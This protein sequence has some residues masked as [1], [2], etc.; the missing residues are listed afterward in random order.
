MRNLKTIR[1]C[2]PSDGSSKSSRRSPLPQPA[3]IAGSRRLATTLSMHRRSIVAVPRLTYGE[4][5]G[6]VNFSE[7]MNTATKILQGNIEREANV[8]TNF[9]SI[10]SR[11][12]N[13][14]IIKI[15]K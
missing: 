5:I 13:D 3:H 1:C 14:P 12:P 4:N 8:A 7:K 11:L 6:L 9:K 2:L 10:V 15:A